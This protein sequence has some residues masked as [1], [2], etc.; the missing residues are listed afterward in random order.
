M[1]IAIIL[2]PYSVGNRP[3]SFSN[4]DIWQ[5]NRGLTG[6]DITL[7]MM[8]ICLAK[9][10][11]VHV[12]TIY[13]GQNKPIMWEGAYLHNYEDKQLIINDSFDCILSLNEPDAFRG[14]T[15][16]PLRVCWQ[17][18]NDFNYC[19]D[20]F[21]NYVDCW[22]GV[23]QSQTKH[24]SSL[25]PET[26]T[27]KWSIL[28]LGC[29]PEWYIDQRV[30]GRVIWCSS[31]D[32]GLHWLLQEWPKIKKAVPYATLKIFYHFNYG[33]IENIEPNTNVN[34]DNESIEARRIREGGD[35]VLKI[36]L[37]HVM[38][39]MAHRVR[40]IKNAI[41][42]LKPF[43]VE[44]IGSI[45][46]DQIKQEFNEA[47]VFGFGCDTLTFSEGFSVSTLEAHASFTVP[48]ISD[49]DSLGEV[50]KN[51]GAL[52]V[53]HPISNHISEFSDLIIKSLTDQQFSNN[54]ID[55]CRAFSQMN[56]WE[57]VSQKFEQIIINHQKTK[58]SSKI[59]L[60]L[61]KK[62]KIGIIASHNWPVPY[63]SHT[64]D[65]FYALLAQ[66]L[67]EMG[68]EVSFF[69]PA[70]SYVPPHGQLLDITCSW[71]SG[72]PSASEYEKETYKKY[73]DILKAQD[74]VH[75]F[76][77][78]KSISA[79]LLAEGYVNVLPQT[80]PGKWDYNCPLRNIIV[81][82][83]AM[84]QRMLRG[85]TDYE[86][87]PTPNAVA[88]FKPIQDAHV[89]N[90]AIDTDFYFPTYQKQNFFLWLGRWHAVRGYKL[91]IELAKQTGINLIM[92]GEHPDREVSQYQ[93]ECS[94]DA[95]KL[96]DGYPNIKF[97]WLPADPEHHIVKRELLQSA[98]ALLF[99][100]QFNEPF[101]LMQAEALACGTPVIGTN[102]GSVPEVILNGITGFVVENNV[103]AFAD[104][105]PLV[106]TISP[107]ICRDNAVR[108][109]D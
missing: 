99:P 82:S 64:G 73:S 52:I 98:K 35:A 65:Y 15:D 100:V 4:H 3:L 10:H 88:P 59:E 91:A 71:G 18:L 55:K 104:V 49:K 57:I 70:G 54:I 77:I 94:A 86:N 7:I 109:F 53:S 39:E 23:S 96:A 84:K 37:S 42:R 56:T 75:D 60:K 92:A 105:L 38:C 5:S 66:T 40:Y 87:T 17:F 36:D 30:P 29:E 25:L 20:G 47:S 28:G 108:R 107:A 63:S 16:K 41:Q 14:L 85:A 45:S 90:H 58:Q 95:V 102:Y 50:Y 67:D 2:G 79:S 33:D 101:G 26:S 69:A 83:E 61:E 106:D 68:H 72:I 93:R 31:A 1:K 78:A 6:T 19:L 48:I 74:I 62:L 81:A 8:S 13:T 44:H 12:F 24:V 97:V 89:V 22:L 9:K 80:L 51:S 43:G 34:F 32:R 46:R 21:D 103:Q 76:S 11:E 27:H